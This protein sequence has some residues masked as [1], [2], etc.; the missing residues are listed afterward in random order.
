MNEVFMTLNVTQIEEMNR[1]IQDSKDL[2]K[3]QA[4]TFKKEHEKVTLILHYG[5]RIEKASWNEE[6]NKWN[7]VEIIELEV[8][9]FEDNVPQYE[10]IMQVCMLCGNNF[11]DHNIE[12]ICTDCYQRTIAVDSNEL[13][14]A[15]GTDWREF[16]K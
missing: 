5:S 8:T 9:H 16:E 11:T 15:L 1:I 14:E 13:A 4:V 3:V 7:V 12:S 10:P 2:Y 6:E